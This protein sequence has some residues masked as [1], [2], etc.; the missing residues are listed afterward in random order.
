MTDAE[1]RASKWQL[2]VDRIDIRRLVEDGT[3]SRTPWR[4]RQGG[5]F[6]R[7]THSLRED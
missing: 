7:L 6:A 1:I 4:V 5:L 3:P 2:L